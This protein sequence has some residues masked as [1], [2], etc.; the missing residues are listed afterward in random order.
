MC[1]HNNMLVRFKN[2][3]LIYLIAYKCSV[4]EITGESIT[5]GV[6]VELSSFIYL[7]IA[8]VLCTKFV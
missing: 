8:Y 6:F 7:Q 4:K 5:N 1:L 2:G 3:T